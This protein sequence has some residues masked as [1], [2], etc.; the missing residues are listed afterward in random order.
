MGQIK[1]AVCQQS[2]DTPMHRVALADVIG[3]D[4]TCCPGCNQ[5]W[6]ID[7]TTRMLRYVRPDGAVLEGRNLRVCRECAG[8]PVDR[9]AMLALRYERGWISD[10]DYALM[11]AKLAAEA[12]EGPPAPRSCDASTQYGLCSRVAGHP[13]RHTYQ[14]VKSQGR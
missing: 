13:G 11:V 12:E 3:A 10:D 9:W 2:A 5:I 4:G 8:M 1:C 14:A 6:P 7:M